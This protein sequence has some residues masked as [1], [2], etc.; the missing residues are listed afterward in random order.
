M[1]DISQATA[2][3]NEAVLEMADDD[4]ALPDEELLVEVRL[5][6][7]TEATDEVEG[8]GNAA[9]ELVERIKESGDLEVAGSSLVTMDDVP[10]Q[11]PRGRYEL[12]LYDKYLKM[13]GKSYDYKVR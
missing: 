9:E 11:V 12:E 2:Q 1:T 7:P 10:V 6:V 8:E 13:H 4:T 5:H 3:K